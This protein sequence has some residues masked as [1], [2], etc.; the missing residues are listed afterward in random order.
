MRLAF[1]LDLA[2]YSTGKTGF[3]VAWQE[4]DGWIDIT[5]YDG[6]IFATKL[7]GTTRL[8]DTADAEQA[9]LLA[10]GRRGVVMIDAPVDL[11]GL[12]L[13]ENPVYLWQLT[14]RPIDYAF[15]A[16]PPLA[17]RIGAPV[18]RLQYLLRKFPKDWVGTRFFETY[19]A[20]A[21][22]LLGQPNKGYK[23]GTLDFQ[24]GK[25][26]GKEMATIATELGWTAHNGIQL[27]SD[28]FDAVL[29]ALSGIV[30]TRYR[31]EGARL[32]EEMNRR[33]RHKMDV[34]EVPAFNA[35]ASFVVLERQPEAKIFIGKKMVNNHHEM[36]QEIIT[37]RK[38]V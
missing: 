27:N 23:Q 3:A 7:K 2:G 1:G 19:P 18:A 26:R 37:L 28:E 14:Q 25:W 13:P 16:M 38:T 32:N 36:V 20:L 10:C 29:C 21:L 8:V 22:D 33:I 30:G 15:G 34:K 24:R 11:Q 12:P 17:D 35:P 4:D 31:L 6:H 5:V 9:L